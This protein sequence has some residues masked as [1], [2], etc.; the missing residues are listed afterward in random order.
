MEAYSSIFS[1]QRD[2]CPNSQLLMQ[3]NILVLIRLAQGYR[4]NHMMDEVVMSM[5]N[6]PQMTTVW[7]WYATLGFVV[8]SHLGTRQPD[9]WRV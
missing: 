5:L 6:Y 8:I 1:F 7:Y 9:M 2:Y 3:A 4:L